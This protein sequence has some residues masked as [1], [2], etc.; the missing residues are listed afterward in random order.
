MSMKI[1]NQI[2]R[3]LRTERGWTQ[4]QLADL[5]GCSLKTIQRV[6][7]SGLCSLETRSALASVFEIELNQLEGEE[8]IQQAKTS[9]DDGLFFYHRLVTGKQVVDV[10]DGTYAYRY[11]NEDARNQ[12]DAEHIAW[13]VQ[14]IN[15]W[16][17][18]WHELEPGSK[19]K[20]TYELSELIVELE[21]KGMWLFGLRTK[22]TFKLPTRDGENKEMEGPVCNFHVAYAD[23]EQIIVLD[24]KQQ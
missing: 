2:V 17:E 7:K 6:E 19:I 14:T 8:K 13:V 21:E 11:S 15:D 18:I 24:A 5:C 9:S 3:R 1:S 12:E 20:A 23:S 22:R 16:S 10:F 4:E